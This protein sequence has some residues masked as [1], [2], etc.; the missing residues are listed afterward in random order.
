[1][2]LL[3]S[4]AEVSPDPDEPEVLDLST[5]DEAL[6]ALGSQTA[7]A[8]LATLYEEPRSPPEVREAVGT[9][10]QNVHYHLERMETAGLI[11]PAGTGYSEKGNE[12]TVYAPARE[13]LVLFAGR[14][15][16]RIRLRDFLPRV[17][18][19]VAVLALAA[20]SFAWFVDFLEPGGQTTAASPDPFA[21]GEGAQG[22]DGGGA[23][24]VL[25]EASS[26]LSEPAIAFFLGGLL[27]AS[28]AVWW[29]E[30]R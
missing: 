10:I 14:E 30:Y 3:P 19:G 13:A 12:M 22:S 18:G 17:L 26:L 9:S 20:L 24:Q 27:V 7:R 15:Q 2:G 1:M 25:A 5:A 28:I 6:D 16:D 11:E 23:S 29:Y 8:I 21:V 4:R